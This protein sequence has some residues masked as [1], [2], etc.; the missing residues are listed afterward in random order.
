MPEDCIKRE[1]YQRG[2]DRLHERIDG[3]ASDVSEI[4]TASKFIKESAD[5]IHEAVFGNGK[6]GALQRITQMWTKITV[7]WW[8]IGTLFGCVGVITTI[9]INHLSLK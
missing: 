4:K 3:I 7:Q 5:K 6:P 8:L 1:E 2:M 9:F